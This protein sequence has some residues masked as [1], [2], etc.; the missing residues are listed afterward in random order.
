MARE[1]SE[2]PDSTL[3]LLVAQGLGAGALRR[4]RAHFGSDDAAARA[5]VEQLRQVKSIGDRAES[6][7][8][9]LDAADPERERRLMA[10]LQARLLLAGDE[11]FPALLA[12]IPD[13]PAALWVRGAIE[14]RDRLGVAVVGSRRCTAYGREQAGRFASVLAQ[15]GLTIVSGGALGIDGEAHRGAMRAGGRTIAVL[16]CGLGLCYPPQHREL[17]EEIARCGGAL[18]TEHAMEAP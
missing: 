5:T 18:V 7:R 15:C 17:F 12:A 14:P 6:L 9:A 2:V 11:D 8:G 16:G 3:R 13:P 4:L 1:P 10:Q